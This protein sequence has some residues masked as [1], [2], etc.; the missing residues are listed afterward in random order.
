VG[1]CWVDSL[2]VEKAMCSRVMGNDLI[3]KYQLDE[4]ESAH[5]GLNSLWKVYPGTHSLRKEEISV[6]ILTKDHLPDYES[7]IM[8]QLF[9]I[10][11]KDL[12]I[13]KELSSNDSYL[14]I[15]EVCSLISLTSLMTLSD[16]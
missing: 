14:K 3:K 8:E 5:G 9:R 1:N 10:M 6:W 7:K 16:N 13:M 11:K 4:T 2:Y 15:H 12:Q